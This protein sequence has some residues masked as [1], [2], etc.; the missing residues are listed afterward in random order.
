MKEGMRPG[1]RLPYSA[2]IDRKPLKLPEG[3]RLVL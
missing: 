1:D 3:A 2:I